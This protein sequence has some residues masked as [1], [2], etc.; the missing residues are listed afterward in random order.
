ML[1]KRNSRA[2]AALT[3]QKKYFDLFKDKLVNVSSWNY[4]YIFWIDENFKDNS[5][6]WQCHGISNRFQEISKQSSYTFDFFSGSNRFRNMQI[7]R[8]LERKE[9]RVTAKEG[10]RSCVDS[11]VGEP[12]EYVVR[13]GILW[14]EY[15][16]TVRE[17]RIA[18]RKIARGC[19][20]TSRSSL[21]AQ[22][23]N[24]FIGAWGKYTRTYCP[25]FAGSF[26][27]PAISSAPPRVHSPIRWA[28][29]LSRLRPSGVDKP[30]WPVAMATLWIDPS[31]YHLRRR[32]KESPDFRE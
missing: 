18:R 26:G 11:F 1:Y 15:A 24:G 29:R 7:R 21:T 14:L 28:D 6:P 31:K 25:P 4:Q 22:T 5:L 3:L 30:G 32:P 23:H 17:L 10:E 19:L 20:Y 9:R 2:S 16:N 8:F 13:A 12:H 27:Q